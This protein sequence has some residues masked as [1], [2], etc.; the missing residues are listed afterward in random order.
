MTY[1]RDLLM[2]FREA[3]IGAK[4]DKYN[5]SSIPDAQMVKQW[6]QEQMEYDLESGQSIWVTGDDELSCVVSHCIAKSA[7]ARDFRV[8]VMTILDLLRELDE[9]DTDLFDI[10]LLVLIDFDD[11]HYEANPHDAKTQHSLE[12]TLMR[13]LR[14]E[15]SILFHLSAEPTWWSPRLM[16]EVSKGVKLRA[17][18]SVE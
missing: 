16:N 11:P 1:S 15:R 17:L 18:G 12:D 4:Y 10:D 9:D 14:L 3:G 13:R 2:A 8:R 7:V 6:V 5:L